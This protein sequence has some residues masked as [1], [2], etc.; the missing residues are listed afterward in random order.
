MADLE[1]IKLNDWKI[2]PTVV[3]R[4]RAI[5]RPE[6]WSRSRPPTRSLPELGRSRPPSRFNKVDFPDPDLPRRATRSPPATSVETPRSAST[7]AS[8]APYTFRTTTARIAAPSPPSRSDPIAVHPDPIRESDTLFR[9]IILPDKSTPARHARLAVAP[10][11]PSGTW[12]HG[13]TPRA[14]PPH[15]RDEAVSAPV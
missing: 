8:F 9:P 3:D 4:N 12:S 15:R 14:S 5:W 11:T 13:P 2:I 7:R 6:S 1:A 10:A